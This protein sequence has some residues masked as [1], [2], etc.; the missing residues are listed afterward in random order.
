MAWFHFNGSPF[1]INAH[2][3]YIPLVIVLMAGISLGLG[4]IISSLTTKYRD[5]AV[6]LTFVIQ[7]AMYATPIAYPLSFLRGKSYR[8]IIDI[9]PLTSLVECFRYALFGKGPLI[10]IPWL[11]AL[12]SCLWYYLWVFFFSIELKRHLWIQ[13]K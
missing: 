13:S 2:W 5:L 12:F 1:T 6:L 10:L 11:I 4:I 3:F 8:W 9:N 7:L